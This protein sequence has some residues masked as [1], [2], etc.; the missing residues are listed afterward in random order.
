MIQIS[1]VN[2]LGML[3]SSDDNYPTI[4]H[5][6]SDEPETQEIRYYMNWRGTGEVEKQNYRVIPLPFEK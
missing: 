4:F 3:F 1:V 2:E 6:V 5:I